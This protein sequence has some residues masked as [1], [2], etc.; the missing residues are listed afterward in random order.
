MGAISTRFMESN[1]TV[2]G[3]YAIRWRLV[4]KC[5]F[6]WRHHTNPVGKEWKWE[7][8]PADDI[9]ND[10]L[11]QHRKM[12]NEMRG[13]PGVT[14]EKLQERHESRHCVISCGGTNHVPRNR[15]VR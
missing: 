2:H 8:N 6:C 4:N 15:E 11:G 10:A 9:V 5:V 13:V 3:N 7:M 1:R 12:I 14:E